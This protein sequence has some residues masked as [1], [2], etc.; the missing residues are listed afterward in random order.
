[1]NCCVQGA[2]KDGAVPAA[3]SL[4]APLAV[5]DQELSYAPVMFTSAGFSSHTDRGP[6]PTHFL[7]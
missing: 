5:T 3:A 1:M 2:T 4:L 7:A 6:P